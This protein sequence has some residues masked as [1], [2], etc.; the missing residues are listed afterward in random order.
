[1]LDAFTEMEQHENAIGLANWEAD[2]AGRPD[3][4]K[5]PKVIWAKVL[6]SLAP[7]LPARLQGE[8]TRGPNESEEGFRLRRSNRFAAEADFLTRSHDPFKVLGEKVRREVQRFFLDSHE[9]R[10]SAL[11]TTRERAG[12]DRAMPRRSPKTENAE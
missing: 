2:H 6:A 4:V 1:M 12:A 10:W 8:V 11:R 9:M 7:E 5:S 3:L